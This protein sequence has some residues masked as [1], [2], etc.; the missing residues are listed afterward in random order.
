MR[1][2]RHLHAD[3]SAGCGREPRR[4]EETGSTQRNGAT[5]NKTEKTI[6]SVSSRFLCSSVLNPLSPSPPCRSKRRLRTGT[7]ANGGN[8]INTEKRSNGEQNGA[9]K[10]FPCGLDSSVPPC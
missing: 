2:L 3:R 8:G 4:T 1:C 9:D 7:E 6:I 10:Y 5:E